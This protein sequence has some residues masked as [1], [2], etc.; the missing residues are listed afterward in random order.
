MG[1][2]H[3]SSQPGVVGGMQW[4]R[5][6]VPCI[7]ILVPLGLVPQVSESLAGTHYQA[8][9]GKGNEPE[10]GSEISL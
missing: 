9:P 6:R 3:R 4:R 7:V 1:P 5:G 10:G 8:Q 2:A